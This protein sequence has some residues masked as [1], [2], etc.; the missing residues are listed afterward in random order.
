MTEPLRIPV[1]VLILG[2]G[3]PILSDD[4]VGIHVARELKKRSIPGVDVE[5]LAASGLEL[6]DVVRGYDKV[7]II[8]AIQ[9][10]KGRPGELHILEEKDFEKSIHGSSPHGINIATA[11]ALGRKLVPAEMPKE[12][13]FFA[14]E[15]EDLVNVS[16]RLTP[17]VAKAL[18]RI[19]E[20]VRK[21]LHSVK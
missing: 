21:E 4:G 7:V 8:D 15:A 18:P 12:V 16:E 17:K 2:V 10:T 9:T 1:R 6:L 5:E 20:L 11:L 13:V 14:V 19:V 3:N